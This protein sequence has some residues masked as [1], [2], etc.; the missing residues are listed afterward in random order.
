LQV[1]KKASVILPSLLVEVCGEKPA[2]FV[3][4]Q[5]IYAD[6]LLTQEM[7]LND[8]FRDREELPRLL[9]NLL[10]ILGAALVDGLPV[11]YVR[12]RVAVPA[13]IVFPSPGVDILS[14]AKKAA[15]QRNSPSGSLFFI[16]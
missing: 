8:G 7:L 6:G 13:V 12:R 2:R 11:L 5:R 15:K 14:P 4:Q 10:P 3:W 1:S 16:D 9:G